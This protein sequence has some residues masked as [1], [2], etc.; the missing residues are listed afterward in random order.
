MD[1]VKIRKSIVLV[2]LLVWEVKILIKKKY[3]TMAELNTD[4][5]GEKVVK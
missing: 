2:W 3:T 4:S 5:G 1:I